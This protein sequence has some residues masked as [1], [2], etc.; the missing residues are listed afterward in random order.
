MHFHVWPSR[1]YKQLMPICETIVLFPDL[2][3]GSKAQ[4]IIYSGTG[5][6]SVGGSILHIVDKNQM[7][8]QSLSL[9]PHHHLSMTKN[10]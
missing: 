10:C 6:N 4:W 2:R 5:S 8:R 3:I 1:G 7:L 9:S